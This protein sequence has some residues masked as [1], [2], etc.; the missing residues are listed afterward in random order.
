MFNNQISSKY[1]I[2]C[3]FSS[4]H[5]GQ[6][7]ILFSHKLFSTIDHL[8]LYCIFASFNYHIYFDKSVFLLCCLWLKSFLWFP[9]RS[10][11]VVAATPKYIFFHRWLHFQHVLDILNLGFALTLKRTSSFHSTVTSIFWVG[12]TIYH[13]L[14][15]LRIY[16][17]CSCNW[18]LY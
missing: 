15:L 8:I 17:S 2:K 6:W 4:R 13:V 10:L 14:L 16:C 5:K 1:F 3:S 11:K 18:S 9:N 12:V 7:S